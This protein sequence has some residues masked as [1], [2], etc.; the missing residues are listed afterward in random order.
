VGALVAA[1]AAFLLWWFSGRAAL[2]GPAWLAV[3]VT[4]VVL[5]AAGATLARFWGWRL[6]WLG[7]ALLAVF[8]AVIMWAFW[9]ATYVDQV[10]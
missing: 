8:G 9:Y 6:K 4:L 7:A 10:R 1:V 3:V 5:A 2:P